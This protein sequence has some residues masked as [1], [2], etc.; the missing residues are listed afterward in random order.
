MS[1]RRIAGSACCPPWAGDPSASSIVS[2]AVG[3]VAPE[4][5]IDRPD[6]T[7]PTCCG[8]QTTRPEVGEWIRAA[9]DAEASRPSRHP[10]GPVGCLSTTKIAA[11]IPARVRR[12]PPP[13]RR[14]GWRGGDEQAGPADPVNASAMAGH[15]SGVSIMFACTAKP[16]AHDVARRGRCTASRCRRRRCRRRSRRLP[17]GEPPSDRRPAPS[18]ARPPLPPPA[19]SS[20]RHRGP[21]AGS[22]IAWL[23]T[24]PTPA[25]AHG[26]MEPTA[27]M[28]VWTATPIS[29]VTVSLSDNR[30]RHGVLRFRPYMSSDRCS[31]VASLEP[32]A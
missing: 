29:P 19:A 3:G 11:H 26:T 27:N 24:A 21:Y 4:E 32:S 15:T 28:H 7:R 6:R 25:R 22:A 13:H 9:V 8:G 20:S 30:I 18:P 12:R 10:V 5:L 17:G 1:A 14:P 31:I 2:S 23:A 16:S